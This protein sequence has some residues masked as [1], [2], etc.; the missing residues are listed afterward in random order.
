VSTTDVCLPVSGHWQGDVEMMLEEMR[1]KKD[2]EERHS[3]P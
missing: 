2:G 3:S 1:M